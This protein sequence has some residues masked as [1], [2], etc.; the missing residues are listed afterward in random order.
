MFE[1]ALA[2]AG[3]RPDQAVM[4]GDNPIADIR[5]AA[6]LGLRTVYRRTSPRPLPAGVRPDAVVDDLRP[7]PEVLRRWI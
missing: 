7:V 2:L 5:G 6:Q 1:R 4:I 3:A